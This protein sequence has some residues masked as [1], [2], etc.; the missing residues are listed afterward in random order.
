MK[1]LIVLLSLFL[2]LIIRPIY[3]E[4]KILI[5]EFLIDPQPQQVELINI[6]SESADISGWYLDDSGGI[7][8]YTIPQSSVIYPNS[9]L[10]FSGDFNLNKTSPDSLRLFNNLSSPISSTSLLIDSFSYKS[11]S[12][13]GISYLRVSDGG[14]LWSTSAANLGLFNSTM[15]SC[16][17]TPTV[18]PSIT[19]TP[20]VAP[21]LTPGA[22][23]S[24]A[25]TPPPTPIFYEKVY[26]NEVMV[27][28]ESGGKEWIE[29]YNDN[30]FDVF[31]TDWFIDDLENAGSAPKKFT[32]IVSAK[33]YGVYYISSSIFNND[34]D[35]VRLLD[36][37]K[38]LKD[39]F[40][41]NG[42]APGYYVRGRRKGCYK[43]L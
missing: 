28:P 43:R 13:S 11:S 33:G 41:Y 25:E 1:S 42:S 4:A 32:I 8:Y 35:N 40:E 21:T 20:T 27:N 2:F 29:I 5:N 23:L 22:E 12:G 18:I 19:P 31:L 16:L 10:V 6:G 17:I 34:G 9:C 14:N 26:L 24:G 37:T 7:T 30:D 3:G 39:S 15:A 36:Q 38:N